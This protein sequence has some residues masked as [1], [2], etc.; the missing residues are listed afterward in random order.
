MN[1]DIKE[2]YSCV[3]KIK[4][5]PYTLAHIFK[6]DY[7]ENFISDWLAFLLN[8]QTN[9]IGMKPLNIFLKLCGKKYKINENPEI[10]IQREYD[11]KEAGRIDFLIKI[12]TDKC[13]K[14]LIAIENK[15]LSD[16][17][18]NQTVK[19]AEKLSAFNDFKEKIFIFLTPTG[20]TPKE[21]ENFI[22]VSYRDYIDELKKIKE[23][24]PR[25]K[26]F[27]FNDFINHFESYILNNKFSETEC[28][29]VKN[30][31]EDIAKTIK[32]SKNRSD[33][34]SKECYNTAIILRNRFF[35]LIE[36]EIKENLDKSWIIKKSS[37]YIQIYQPDWEEQ[38]VH[39]EI[40]IHENKGLL[41]N[42]CK[43]LVMLHKEKGKKL[44]KIEK[45]KS[46]F[47]KPENVLK[48]KKI[49][50]TNTFNS[51]DDIKNTINDIVKSLNKMIKDSVDEVN[52]HLK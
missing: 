26:Q 47:N 34:E 27:Y 37:F 35:D 43:L 36:T 20:I 16:E 18:Y 4:D 42:E 7:G 31:T 12:K 1:E 24:V 44:H 13:E 30:F 22:A 52:Q 15:I 39:Y 29:F 17:G 41:H 46:S 19:Y 11:L 5:K 51:H 50:T 2:L 32:Y 28:E 23:E 9:G 14:F 40:I 8:P 38:G 3:M 21:R 45:S 10:D 6:K 49:I 33:N 48:E 25:D